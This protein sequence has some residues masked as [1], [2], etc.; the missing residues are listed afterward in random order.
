MNIFLNHS[1]GSNYA[2]HAR[3]H[4]LAKTQVIFVIHLYMP[5]IGL[6][7]ICNMMNIRRCCNPL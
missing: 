6:E 4:F 2:I 7:K 1:L 5:E 3:R